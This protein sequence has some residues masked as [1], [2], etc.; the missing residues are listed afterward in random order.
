MAYGD[1]WEP[2]GSRCL[3]MYFAFTVEPLGF[4]NCSWHEAHTE[5]NAE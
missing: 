2:A 4:P 1:I 3:C 5:I